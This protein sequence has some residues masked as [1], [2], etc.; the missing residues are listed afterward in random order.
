MSRNTEEDVPNPLSVYG[1]SKLEG[2]E[3][4]LEVSPDSCVIRISWLFDNEMPCFLTKMRDL[5]SSGQVVKVVTDQV[6]RPTYASDVANATLQLL[7]QS[8]IWHFAN[9]GAVSRHAWI[10]SVTKGEVGKALS[11]DF[12]TP[13]KRPAYSV[14]ST[15]KIEQ[16]GVSVRPWQ[17]CV[18]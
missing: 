12:K 1:K 11:A 7:D 6:G 5:I 2:E 17:N 4:L 13:A 16:F 3:K 14:L 18:S 9:Q 10:Q 15:E 8:G